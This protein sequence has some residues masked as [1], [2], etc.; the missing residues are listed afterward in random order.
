M[1]ICLDE[2]LVRLESREIRFICHSTAEGFIDQ[3][4]G[5]SNV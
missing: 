4:L 2:T 3:E 1:E 5:Q